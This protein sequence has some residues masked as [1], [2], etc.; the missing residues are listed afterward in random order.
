MAIKTVA[1]QS[2]VMLISHMGSKMHKL[3]P[4]SP[5]TMV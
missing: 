1:A 2:S 3:P 4:A 5:N